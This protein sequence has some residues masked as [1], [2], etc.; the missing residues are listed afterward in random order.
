MCLSHQGV[1]HPLRLVLVLIPLNTFQ[2]SLPLRIQPVQPRY[3]L[4]IPRLVTRP[5]QHPKPFP[6][7]RPQHRLAT[8]GAPVIG[9][10]R[11]E[12]RAELGEEA[13]ELVG[14]ETEDT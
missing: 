13:A 3:P 11:D 1:R 4:Q 14:D 10:A 6:F 7:V 5:Q 9:R 8:P 2:R 12:E